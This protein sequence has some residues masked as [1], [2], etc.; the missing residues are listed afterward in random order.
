[1]QLYVASS[2]RMGGICAGAKAINS[3]LK[4][5]ATSLDAAKGAVTILEGEEGRKEGK[6][7][8]PGSQLG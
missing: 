2:W 5:V 8:I 7:L 1:M 4:L 6:L 3:V